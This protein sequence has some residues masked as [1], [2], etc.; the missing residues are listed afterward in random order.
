MKGSFHKL[1]EIVNTL[2]S[3]ESGRRASH[4]DVTASTSLSTDDNRVAR[5]EDV[6]LAS[7]TAT[8]EGISEVR[9]PKLADQTLSTA[10]DDLVRTGTVDVRGESTPSNHPHPSVVATG[11]DTHPP[12]VVAGSDTH[13]PVVVAGSDTHPPVVVAGSDTHPPVVFAGSDTH[14]PVVVAGSD[15]H[16]PVVFAGSDT[17]PPVVVAGSDTHPPVVVA[18]S[19]THPPVIVT[20]S[21][22]HPPV[23]ATGS[24]THLPVVVTGSDTHPPVI[25]AESNTHP[26]VVVTGSDTHPIEDASPDPSSEVVGF[27]QEDKCPSTRVGS[28]CLP[29]PL[30]SVNLPVSTDA[31]ESCL[32]DFTG[33]ELLS[34]KDQYACDVCT[35]LRG[36]RQTLTVQ[37]DV[38]MD[39]SQCSKQDNSHP[40]SDSDTIVATGNGDQKCSANEENSK[41]LQ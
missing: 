2:S 30:S 15:T 11:S 34:G 25:V 6:V 5:E 13:P 36:R 8:H 10:S 31:L 40:D 35:E 4:P 23:V 38:T 17:H 33:C 24:D 22:T 7:N 27:E 19:D 18:G 21:D 39:T 32:L 41:F 12:V 20:G 9:E 37:G 29:S 16:P 14:P 1:T 28:S 3:K 26:P